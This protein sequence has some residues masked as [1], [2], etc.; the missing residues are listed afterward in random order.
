METVQEHS[1]PISGYY[2]LSLN[3]VYATWYID[4]SSSTTPTQLN[5]TYFRIYSG[6]WPGGLKQY[7]EQSWGCSKVDVLNPDSTF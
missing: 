7:M 6:T 5:E 4:N 3:G 2:Y 1:P